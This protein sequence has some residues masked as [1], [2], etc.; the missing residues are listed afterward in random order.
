MSLLRIPPFPGSNA[1]P[2]SA[3]LQDGRAPSEA[4]L[5]KA[6][7]LIRESRAAGTY[8]GSRPK[9]PEAPYILVRSQF[10]PIEP[11]N[12]MPIVAWNCMRQKPYTN[13]SPIFHVSGDCDP[14]H[15]LEGALEVFTDADD[16]LAVIAA[17]A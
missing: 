4:Y 3:P 2:F 11:A 17:I 1:G 5:R 16:E 6:I 15:L 12:E 14:W 9:M 8:W 10:G 13:G 7:G